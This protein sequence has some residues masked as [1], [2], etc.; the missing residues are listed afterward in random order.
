MMGVID[1]GYR[2]ELFAGAFNLADVP[3]VLE[4]GERVAQLILMPMRIAP[5]VEVSELS[6]SERGTLGFGSTGR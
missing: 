2:G 1:N 5:L 4:V 6:D 3:V